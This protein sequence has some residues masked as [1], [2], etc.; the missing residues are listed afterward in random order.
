LVPEAQRDAL[1]EEI[2]ARLDWTGS[3]WR[4]SALKADGTRLLCYKIWDFLQAEW[5]AE[6]QAR[7]AAVAS[8]STASSAG[9]ASEVDE[10]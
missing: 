3:V 2:V 7:V 5:E 10:S 4:V 1:C 6:K 8:P 9:V